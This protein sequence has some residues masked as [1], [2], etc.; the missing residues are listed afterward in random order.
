MK[1]LALPLLAVAAIA[2][3]DE[4]TFWKVDPGLAQHPIQ[5]AVAAERVAEGRSIVVYREKGY[6]FS[7]A[8]ADDERAQVESAIAAFDDVIYPRQVALFGPC[9]D[10]DGNGKVIVLLTAL[11][12]GEGHYFRFDGMRESEALASGFHSNQAEVLYLA[13]RGQ[14]NRA[15]ANLAVLAR[16]FHELLHTARDPAETSWA[17]VVGRHAAFSCGVAPARLLWGEDDPLAAAPSPGDPW[18]PHG[19][20]Q[21]FV[22]Y[23]HE[24]L[25]DPGLTALVTSTEPGPA[26]LSAAGGGVAGGFGDSEALADFALACWLDDPRLGDGRFGF[27]RVT[28]PRP[29]LVARL[30]ASRPTSGQTLVGAGG[31]AYLLIEADRER[32]LSLTL[33]GD[34]RARWLG[35]AVLLRR[36]GPDGQ[37]PLDFEA[38]GIAK[39]DL[40]ALHAGDALLVAVVP[41]PADE[42]GLDRRLVTLQWGLGWVPQVAAD[43]ARDG[44]LELLRPQLPD[45]GKAARTR[46][47]TTVARLGGQAG[48][49]P[50]PPLSTRYAWSPAAADV[51]RALEEEAQHRGLTS[52]LTSFLRLAPG[53][54]RQ[55]WHNVLIDLP[56]RDP[57][58][59]PVVLAAHWDGARSRLDD[60]YLRAL[61]LDDNASGVAVALEA[62]AAVARVPHRAPVVVALLGGG[63]HGHAGADALLSELQGKA[64]AWIELEGVGIPEPWPR[65]L[66][67][68]LA[69]APESDQ[70]VS[71]VAGVLRAAGLTPR[72][73]AAVDVDHTGLIPATSRRIPALVIRLGDAEADLDEPPVAEQARL[74]PELMVLLAKASATA[75]VKVAG[76][77]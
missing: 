20:P 3:A 60:S 17:A 69:A 27:G 36:D 76:A 42:Y 32:S 43:R 67:V 52:R 30:P 44:F 62:A 16:V 53:D 45:G 68:T 12:H 6:V 33:R 35:R 19:W 77:P 22:Q 48:G 15:A 66:S 8:G 50:T 9:P 41:V 14:G 1:S 13:F 4:R 25:G 57:R 23:L 72:R 46:L 75:V 29:T 54:L 71:S 63:Y 73:T 49:Q 64:S 61:N 39:L 11:S 7:A 59:W 37:R 51:V 2:H 56:G 24:R 47:S 58:R 70:L 21:L 38:G 28:P 18:S 55:E 40:E 26:A 34:P 31:M 74:S 10:L 5:T 65:H